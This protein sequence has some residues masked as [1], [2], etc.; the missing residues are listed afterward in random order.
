MKAVA[1]AL[2]AL[3]MIA[4]ARAQDAPPSLPDPA[5]FEPD[6]AAFEAPA[7]SSIVTWVEKN[8]LPPLQAPEPRL[9]PL[10][11]HE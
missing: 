6:I 3:L 7:D 10:L 8:V 1:P 2:F 4:P 11:S 5:R 9:Q